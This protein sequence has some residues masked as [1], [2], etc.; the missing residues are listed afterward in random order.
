MNSDITVLM[1]D[2]T[3]K[4]NFIDEKIMGVLKENHKPT[5][6]V[7][8]KIDELSVEDRREAELDIRTKFKFA[9]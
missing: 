3:Q 7:I 5:I 1:I 8:N 9:P 4:V 2:P 6:V